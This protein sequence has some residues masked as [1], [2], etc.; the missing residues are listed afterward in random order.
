MDFSS[1]IP[2]LKQAW[3]KKINTPQT[4]SIGRL[5]DAAAALCGV[6]NL[7]SYE[8]QG[9]MEFEALADNLT[10]HI[11][12]PLNKINDCHVADWEPLIPALLDTSFSR[13]ERSS[14]FHHSLAVMLL[15]QARAIRNDHATNIVSFSGGVFQ[16]K[17]LTESAIALL[18]ADGFRVCLPEEIPLN[19]AGISFGQIIEYGFKQAS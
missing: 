2:L 17:L 11:E 7:A 16:N 19:D 18:E 13:G 9:P 15:Q 14:L 4:T 6:C 5:F 12:L 3:H 8:G 1:D 10:A